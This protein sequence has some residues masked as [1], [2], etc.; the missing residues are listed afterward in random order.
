MDEVRTWQWLQWQRRVQNI[1]PNSDRKSGVATRV[2]GS[3]KK[4]NKKMKYP[5]V[6]LWLPDRLLSQLCPPDDLYPHHRTDCLIVQTT[7][8][9]STHSFHK[10]TCTGRTAYV[11]PCGLASCRAWGSLGRSPDTQTTPGWV[12]LVPTHSSLESKSSQQA[13]T[14]K[15]IVIHIGWGS[16]DTSIM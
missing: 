14:L 15:A 16:Y 10:L 6:S 11:S 13:E 12:R 1:G 3:P 2:E 5:V 7:Q 8:T 4:N 9:P